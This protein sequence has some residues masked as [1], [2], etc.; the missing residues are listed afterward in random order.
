MIRTR[1]QEALVKQLEKSR[2]NLHE[3]LFLEQNLVVHS[4]L[5]PLWS[6]C[7]VPGVV[8]E[9][10]NREETRPSGKLCPDVWLKAETCYNSVFSST[11]IFLFCDSPEVRLGPASFP[12]NAECLLSKFIGLE[13]IL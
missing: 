10:E 4:V 1:D 12:L 5:K 9:T 6:L 11:R 3:S 8:L 7:T 2:V 13:G